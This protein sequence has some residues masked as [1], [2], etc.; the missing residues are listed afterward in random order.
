MQPTPTSSNFWVIFSAHF[1]KILLVF[2][3]MFSVVFVVVAITSMALVMKW[4]SFTNEKIIEAIAMAIVSSIGNF[5]GALLTLLTGSRMFSRASEAPPK[6]PLPPGHD[7]E[8]SKPPLIVIPPPMPEMLVPA[9]T[10]AVD[11]AIA[12]NVAADKGKEKEKP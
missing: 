5:T 4:L 11:E 2:L 9:A 3:Y 1:D 7:G 6:E 10:A 8:P 12:V